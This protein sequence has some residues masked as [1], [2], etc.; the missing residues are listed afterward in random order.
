MKREAAIQAEILI[1][2]TAIP[3]AMFERMNTGAAR[4]P[5]G[6][7]VRFGTPGGPDIRGTLNGQAVAIEC[8]TAKGRLRPDQL[9]WRECFERAG[10]RYIIGRDAQDVIHA[11]N[12]LIQKEDIHVSS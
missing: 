7:L 4:T 5:D 6:R 8:K 9:R 11:L 3:G 1:A 10:G 12:T 2:V